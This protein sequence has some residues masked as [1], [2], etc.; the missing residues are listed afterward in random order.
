[1]KKEEAKPV[2]KTEVNIDKVETK[3]LLS[4]EEYDLLMKEVKKCQYASDLLLKKLR[5][6]RFLFVPDREEIMKEVM[7]CKSMELQ[8]QLMQQK[9]GQ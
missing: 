4:Y 1:M 7:L 9:A 3:A 5:E 6:Q 8:N 2:D